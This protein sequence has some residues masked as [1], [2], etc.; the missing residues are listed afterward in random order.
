M[1]HCVYPPIFKGVEEAGL[2]EAEVM[3]FFRDHPN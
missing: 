2:R 1:P 3:N